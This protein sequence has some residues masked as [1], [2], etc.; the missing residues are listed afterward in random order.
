M[1]LAAP[2][3]TIIDGAAFSVGIVAARFNHEYVDTL[4]ARVVAGLESL[5]VQPGRISVSRVPGSNE[6]PIAAQWLAYGKEVPDVVIGLGVL[7]RGDTIHYELI[8]DAATHALQEVAL[9]TGVPVINGI[10]VAETAVQAQVRC[11]GSIDRG[12]EFAHAALE[13]AA[14]KRKLFR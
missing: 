12:I 7:I 10:I 2:K 3:P 11:G 1:S 5:G 9:K 6:V 8:A 14:L 13:M 4:L